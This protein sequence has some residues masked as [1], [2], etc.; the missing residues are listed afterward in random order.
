MYVVTMFNSKYDASIP[1]AICVTEDLEKANEV[2]KKEINEIEG[3]DGIDDF[4]NTLE[5]SVREG[6]FNLV[7]AD[8]M[9][10]ICIDKIEVR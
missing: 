2:F 10:K 5:E 7:T 6:E 9:V 1:H 8:I 4:G 3:Y